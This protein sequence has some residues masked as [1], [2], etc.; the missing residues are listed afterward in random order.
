[1]VGVGVSGGV[2]GGGGGERRLRRGRGSEGST[3]MPLDFG[4]VLKDPRGGHIGGNLLDFRG[5]I[6]G[7]QI[8]KSWP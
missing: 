8:W 7:A 5:M 2:G 1:M 4:I 6:Y 3:P